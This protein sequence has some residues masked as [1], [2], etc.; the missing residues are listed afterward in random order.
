MIDYQEIREQLQH[1]KNIL[2]TSHRDPD[3]D[4][5]GS[6]LALQ[7]WLAQYGHR[8]QIAFP[9][10]F[11]EIFLWMEKASDILIYDD[12]PEEID[13][14]L[15]LTD[16]VFSVD[17]NSLQRIDSLGKAIEAKT[18]YKIM[19]D[20]HLYP[21]GFADQALSKTSASSTCE[22][23]F[24]F[25]GELQ[26]LDK[27]NA[28]IARCLLTGIITDTG[29][30]QHNV[31]PSTF[32]TASSLMAFGIDIREINHYI[33]NMLP[34]KNLRLLGHCLSSRMEVIPKYKTG[35]IFLNKMDYQVFDIVRGDTEGIVN[36]LLKIKD[37]HFAV[38]I[39]Q[40]P[41]IIKFSFRSKGDLN[42][43]KI[44]RDHFN[45]GGHKNAAGGYLYTSLSKALE[46]VKSILPEYQ[47]ELIQIPYK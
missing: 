22:L 18:S 42:V 6:S 40:Q 4:A 21:D 43:E 1:P 23:V 47:E 26:G 46:K 8:V 5:I 9:S 29:S 38:F 7:L 13:R 39:R 37:V 33:F 3:G 17:Y 35:I 15:E 41:K 44:A 32:Q 11:P 34:E 27:M 14:F 45:G 12:T 2:I 28:D 20:H 31:F 16:I 10:E 30:F 36:Y 19:I 25:I 24:E